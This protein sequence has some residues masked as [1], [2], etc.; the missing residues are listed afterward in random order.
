MSAADL[1][2]FMKADFSSD[3]ALR[4]YEDNDIREKL[5]LILGK[6]DNF[7]KILTHFLLDLVEYYWSLCAEEIQ[8]ND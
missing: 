2:E 3:T 7:E 5:E 8:D 1:E 6:Q 4:K